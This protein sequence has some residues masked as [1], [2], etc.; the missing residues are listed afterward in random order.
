MIKVPTMALNGRVGVEAT[1]VHAASSQRRTRD[2]RV[3]GERR[4][5]SWPMRT[6]SIGLLGVAL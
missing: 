1:A 3:G 5:S 2:V 4:A 6:M